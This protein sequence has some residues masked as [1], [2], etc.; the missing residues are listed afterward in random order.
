MIVEARD[1]I[2]LAD[3]F[4][5]GAKRENGRCSPGSAGAEIATVPTA[6]GEVGAVHDPRRT[7]KAAEVSSGRDVNRVAG[8]GAAESEPRIVK[9]VFARSIALGVA[10]RDDE[11]VVGH[12]WP[13]WIRSPFWT[14]HLSG[15]RTTPGWSA[16]P[17]YGYLSMRLLPQPY[18]APRPAH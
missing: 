8:L 14:A 12:S 18:S 16:G 4:I 13:R 9:G 11:P 10:I 6:D 3:G 7:V 1:E 17:R 2:V 5:A 15:H